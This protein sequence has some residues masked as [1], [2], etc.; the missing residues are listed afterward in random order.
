MMKALKNILLYCSCFS[1]FMISCAK[2]DDTSSS[3]SSSAT[4]DNTTTSSDNTTSSFSVSEITQTTGNGYKI[5]S[6]VVPSNGLSFTLS[7]FSDNNSLVYFASL[8]DP[9]A[10]NLLDN[11]STPNIYAQ[12]SGFG[13]LS[14]GGGSMLVPYSSSFS[15]KAGTW[16]FIA[17]NNDRVYLG[18]RTGSTPSSTTISI[19]P[20]ITGT[21]WS[22]SDISAALT[23]MSNIYS[24]NGITLTIKD[25]ITISESQ[26]ST[27]SSSF[28]NSTTSA[29]ISQ[30]ST[31]TVNLFF[32]ED[33]LSGESA[34]Y[35]VSGGLPGPTGIASSWNGVLNFLTAHA[36]GTTLNTQ[37]LGETAAHE[38]GHWLGLYH[39]SEST[40]TSFDPLSD[41]AE[42]PISRDNDS[43]GKVYPEECDG[44]GADNV[45]FWTAWS[46]SSQAAGKKQETISREQK[47]VLKYSPIAK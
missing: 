15:A 23:V 3:S 44:Y 18:L 41:T 22:A 37:L 9:D 1:L 10:S 31:D 45:M 25:T 29:L 34:A 20:Y 11:T 32:V 2:K 5:G 7:I 14:Y 16:S 26:Y 4:T 40:G 35:G 12:T 39:T 8:T 6:F 42:C 21:T 17:S 46:T 38:M 13:A 47:Y 33:Q 36:T 43:D 24:T 30:G 19:Q 28:S 27:I